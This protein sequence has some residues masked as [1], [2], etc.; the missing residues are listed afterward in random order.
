M[1]KKIDVT[2]P[3]IPGDTE[4]SVRPTAIAHASMPTRATKATMRALV[5]TLP[6]LILAQMPPQKL[7]QQ[8]GSDIY[9]IFP[10]YSFPA[11]IF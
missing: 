5:L 11:A 7:E 8:P 2:I 9:R 6:S 4:H 3:I 10:H 1:I